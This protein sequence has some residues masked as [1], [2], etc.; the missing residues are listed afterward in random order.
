MVG[1]NA[2]HVSFV[3][4]EI[5]NYL[6]NSRAWSLHRLIQSLEIV[7]EIMPRHLPPDHKKVS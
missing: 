2:A 4:P 7:V 3:P 6:V 1:A 5:R